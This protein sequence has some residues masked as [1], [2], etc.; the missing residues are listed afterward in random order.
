M[1]NLKIYGWGLWLQVFEL[2]GD[3]A[4]EYAESGVMSESE[5]DEYVDDAEGEFYS[6]GTDAS[7]Y[8]DGVEI[9]TISSLV[10]LTSPTD[11]PELHEALKASGYV[12]DKDNAFVYE[13][14]LKGCFVDAEIPD[15]DM[16]SSGEVSDSFLKDFMSSL[17]VDNGRFISLTDWVDKELPGDD[18]A[19][20]KSDDAY[21]I[22]GG[23]R[24]EFQIE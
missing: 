7:V 17:Y 9:G 22:Y 5:Y 11:Y 14:G 19:E 6:F 8:Y 23:K 4:Q 16:H 18:S 1:A 12:L 2:D 10:N 20:A 13:Q 15:Y 24:Y 21:I 3:K